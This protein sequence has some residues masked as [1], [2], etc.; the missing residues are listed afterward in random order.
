MNKMST[1]DKDLSIKI[2]RS[3][4][5]RARGLG[6]AQAGTGHWWAQ[7]VSAVALLP[8]SLYFVLSVIMLLGADVSQMQ[9]YMS[10]PW[11]CALFLALIAMLFYHL[12][13]GM[14]VVI[15]D[16]IPNEAK[17][18]VTLMIVDGGIIFLAIVCAISVLKLAFS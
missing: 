10:E 15:E 13:L 9:A 1:Q 5:G 2:Y 3:G 14:R 8:L 17:R 6:S 12:S 4:L 7:R 16:Y 11:N 18:L